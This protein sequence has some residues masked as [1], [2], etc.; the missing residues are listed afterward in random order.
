ADAWSRGQAS[1]ALLV[2]YN[3]QVC[4]GYL[5]EDGLLVTRATPLATMP[6]IRVMVNGSP[7]AVLEVAGFEGELVVLRV[8]AGGG[9]APLAPEA[10]S[11]GEELAFA[12]GAGAP[13]AFQSALVLEP[14]PGIGE[15][16]FRFQGAAYP[17][18]AGSP[19][20]NSRGEVIG[21]VLGK[22]WAYPGSNFSIGVDTAALYSA[23]QKARA[24]TLSP[25]P[26]DPESFSQAV[27]A[28][29]LSSLPDPGDSQAA[30]RSNARIQAGRSM[31]NYPIGMSRE[32][33]EREFGAGSVPSFPGGFRTV[34]VDP[35]PLEFTLL[36]D[37]VVAISTT[38]RFYATARGGGV[39]ATLDVL[40]RDPAFSNR[41][42]GVPPGGRRQVLIARGV[43]ALVGPDRSGEQLTVVLEPLGAGP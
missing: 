11:Q 32:E 25:R 8:P 41:V 29:M 1:T 43:E 40:Q 22:P 9:G 38:D 35:Y 42:V 27:R 20:I 19:L 15:G 2:G 18:N 36:D 34:R 7:L 37:R 3:D 21:L 23:L 12:A 39:G 16:T 4:C 33:L 26:P 24:G 6:G 31:G 10:P 14:T 13:S 30:G 17:T 5:A 28:S